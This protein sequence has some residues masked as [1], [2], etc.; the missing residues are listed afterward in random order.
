M[1]AGSQSCPKRMTCNRECAFRGKVM[2]VLPIYSCRV[3]VP[4]PD[5]PRIEWPGP[6]ASRCVNVAACTT[7]R[8]DCASV[9]ICTNYS[10]KIIQ[11]TAEAQIEH[12]LRTDLFTG[13]CCFAYVYKRLQFNCFCWIW[14]L[15]WHTSN[16]KWYKKVVKWWVI[17][18]LP[19]RYRNSFI[20]I[21]TLFY[22]P[23]PDCWHKTQLTWVQIE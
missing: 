12:E 1:Q 6:L 4:Q 19:Y 15:T 18:N 7:W 17:S 9:V 5:L 14:N 22:L 16:E 11:T 23:V 13:L 3:D 2:F 20:A 21:F 10:S 8:G